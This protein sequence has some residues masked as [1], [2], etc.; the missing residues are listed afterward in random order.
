LVRENDCAD[1]SDEDWALL[2]RL[3]QPIPT[4]PFFPPTATTDAKFGRLP[5]VH[6]EC[7]QDRALPLPLQ[8]RFQREARIETV[9]ARYKS[10]SEFLCPGRAG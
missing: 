8:R 3:M 10:L 7:L 5:K 4:A 2:E 1:C 6:I 9:F